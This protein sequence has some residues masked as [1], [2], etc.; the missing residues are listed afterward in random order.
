MSC[1]GS[2]IFFNFKPYVNYSPISMFLSIAMQSQH[3]LN[4]VSSQCAHGKFSLA[5]KSE[6]HPKFFNGKKKKLFKNVT[7]QILNFILM[8]NNKIFL[9]WCNVNFVSTGFHCIKQYKKK[10]RIFNITPY[11]ENFHQLTDWDKI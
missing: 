6:V 8:F 5:R 9:I 7:L 10:Q 3:R 2:Y 4:S 1:C 11:G